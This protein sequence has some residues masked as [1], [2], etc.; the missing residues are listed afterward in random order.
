MIEVRGVRFENEETLTQ[1]ISVLRAIK[2]TSGLGRDDLKAI[3]SIEY[4]RLGSVLRRLARIGFICA[5]IKRKWTLTAKGNRFV[6]G[7]NEN[8]VN[9]CNNERC[10]ALGDDEH[11]QWMD[12]WK[13]PREERRRMRY[14][15]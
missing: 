13:K 7:F 15:P 2:E 11:K 3:T 10:D 4:S 6:S 14:I 8:M 5:G 9:K 1:N 12:Y